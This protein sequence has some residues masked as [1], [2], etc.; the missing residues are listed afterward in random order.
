MIAVILVVVTA[1]EIAVSY[2]DGD[3]PD[4]LIVALLLAMAAIKFA[5]G[6]VVLHAPPDR[7]AD[8]PPLLRARESSP[9]SSLYA[10]V[11]ATLHVL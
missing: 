7:P 5:T 3:I 8:L 1:V 9:R 2:L 10:V 11:L 4:G 6:R